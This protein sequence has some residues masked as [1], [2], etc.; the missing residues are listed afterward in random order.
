MNITLEGLL[1]AKSGGRKFVKTK[2]LIATPRQPLL[3]AGSNVLGSRQVRLTCRVKTGHPTPSKCI[4]GG[5]S[6]DKVPNKKISTELPRQFEGK[7]PYGGKPHAR[8]V[9]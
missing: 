2:L 3:G 6:V 5:V 8:M 7:D 1:G 9:V 4:A